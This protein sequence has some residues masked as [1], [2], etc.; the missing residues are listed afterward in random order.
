MIEAMGLLH[1]GLLEW[2]YVHTKFHENLPSSSKVIS[3]GH[4][5]RQTGDLL[6]LL[7]FLRSRLIRPND[8][9]SFL[10]R[11]FMNVATIKKGVS[12]FLCQ[13][14]SSGHQQIHKG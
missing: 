3:G 4:T 6:S 1:R 10:K 11:A 7:S 13:V 12:R 5:D 8:V 9:S 14:F 2:H